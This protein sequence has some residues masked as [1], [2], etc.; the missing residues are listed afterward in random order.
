MRCEIGCFQK[1]SKGKESDWRCNPQNDH[2]DTE[3]CLKVHQMNMQSDCDAEW[4]D[5]IS[6]TPVS[7]VFEQEIFISKYG[8]IRQKTIFIDFTD[9]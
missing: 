5:R 6:R 8:T 1:E 7:I 2:R 3:I 9:Y 4:C